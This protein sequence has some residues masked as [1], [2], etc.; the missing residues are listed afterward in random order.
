MARISSMRRNAPLRSETPRPPEAP[1]PPGHLRFL[2]ARPASC[3]DLGVTNS[4]C[5]SA[6]PPR[7]EVRRA[8]LCPQTW[9]CVRT[10][11]TGPG[12]G[13]ALE[14]AGGVNERSLAGRGKYSRSACSRRQEGSGQESPVDGILQCAKGG[15]SCRWQTGD[16]KE[17]GA[18][19]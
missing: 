13:G 10:P 14:A 2:P 15:G 4:V 16:F 5:V 19:G 12:P 8:G 18:R 3:Q 17:M 9:R 7:R 1:H 11:A 6:P